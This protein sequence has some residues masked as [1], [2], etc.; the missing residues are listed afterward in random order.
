MC[1][2]DTWKFVKSKLRVYFAIWYLHNLANKYQWNDFLNN[3]LNLPLPL[4][5]S[6][7]LTH[8][9]ST[10]YLPSIKSMSM[11]LCC[12]SIDFMLSHISSWSKV[13]WS[14]TK[15]SITF[16]HSLRKVYII[17]GS[18]RFKSRSKIKKKKYTLI[19]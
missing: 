18:S 19:S 13:T 7:W 12:C 6:M 5:T 8:N 1:E 3:P 10:I 4:H 14:R 16:G 17:S 2:K 11:F 9:N 15:S